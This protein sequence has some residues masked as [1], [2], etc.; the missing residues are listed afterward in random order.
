M[1]NARIEVGKHML[2]VFNFGKDYVCKNTD[3]PKDHTSGSM[4]RQNF[5][6]DIIHLWWLFSLNADSW[7]TKIDKY[8]SIH[9]LDGN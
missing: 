3:W 6:I 5:K 8:F 2:L 1:L 7:S 4:L 9:S